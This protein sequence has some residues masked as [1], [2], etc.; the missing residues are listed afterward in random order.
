MWDPSSLAG[1]ETLAFLEGEVYYHWTTRE[2][3]PQ[4]PKPG[5]WHTS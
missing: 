3:P 1:I 4:P 5:Y 2:V